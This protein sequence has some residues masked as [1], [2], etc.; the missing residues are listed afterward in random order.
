M[1]GRGLFIR[2][3]LA[4]FPVATMKRYHQEEHD[5]KG[6]PPRKAPRRLVNKAELQDLKT[7]LR[8]RD[9]VQGV[10]HGLWTMDKSHPLNRLLGAVPSDNFMLTRIIE[11]SDEGSGL[12]LA[13]DGVACGTLL[14]PNT[15]LLLEKGQQAA[16]GRGG[17]TVVDTKV[18]N[19]LAIEGSRVTVGGKAVT[20]E[21]L[22]RSQD[23]EDLAKWL[24]R[25][26]GHAE[27][28]FYKAHVYPVGGHFDMHRDTQHG[29]GHVGTVVVELP[30]GYTT[31][32]DE[33]D[34]GN[35]KGALEVFHGDTSRVLT[36]PRPGGHI[37]S[38]GAFYASCE[39]RVHT[40]KTAPR[41]V[42]QFD[43]VL[44]S[45]Q[46]PEPMPEEG[47]GGDD[48]DVHESSDDE[49]TKDPREFTLDLLESSLPKATMDVLQRIVSMVREE[50][51]TCSVA[52]LAQ[53]DYV[54]STLSKDNLKASDKVLWDTLAGAGLRPVLAMSVM[55]RYSYR[56][57]NLLSAG[58]LGVDFEDNVLFITGRVDRHLTLVERQKGADYTGNEAMPDES[59]YVAA[60]IVVPC[61]NER[62]DDDGE[63]KKPPADASCEVSWDEQDEDEDGEKE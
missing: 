25:P 8:I 19:A 23:V 42:L 50:I 56:D 62:G 41:V 53:Y 28:R 39:H 40:I 24:G 37:L 36:H 30:T 17:E 44:L 11:P 61:A 9:I 12:D 29:A 3:N 27:Y 7:Y 58:G 1:G 6:M 16:F 49:C 5:G 14:A 15:A 55:E 59:R 48:A 20:L 47:D 31:S 46:P 52:F 34:A 22:L 33:A 57:T 54:N 63:V 35:I 43:V 60:V 38:M 21:G 32:F 13:I 18:R 26:M 2:L 10:G 45:Q 51:Q 4:L